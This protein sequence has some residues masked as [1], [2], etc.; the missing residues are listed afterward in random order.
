AEVSVTTCRRSIPNARKDRGLIGLA[1]QRC[2]MQPRR[3]IARACGG[4]S[5]LDSIPQRPMMTVGPPLHFAAQSSAESVVQLLLKAGA[6]ADSR[7]S[8][9]NTPLSRAVYNSRG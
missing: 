5:L 6:P 1:V 2:I 8:H 3:V 4:S 7:D 9:G